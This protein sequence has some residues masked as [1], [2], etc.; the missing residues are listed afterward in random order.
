MVHL[1]RGGGCLDLSESQALKFFSLQMMVYISN[2][3]FSSY[4]LQ[5]LYH[6]QVL[7][8]DINGQVE[9]EPFYSS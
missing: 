6:I 8:F 4:I 5:K 7:T 1:D 2:I 9:A 3:H